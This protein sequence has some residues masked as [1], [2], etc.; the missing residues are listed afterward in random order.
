MDKKY[1]PVYRCIK[2]FYQFAFI[3]MDNMA[4]GCPIATVSPAFTSGSKIPD[5]E[6]L[7]GI[8]SVSLTI[9]GFISDGP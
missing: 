1:F 5:S 3:R 2:C 8:S 4:S 6:V 7:T 9:F